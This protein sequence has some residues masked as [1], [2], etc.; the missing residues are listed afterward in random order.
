MKSGKKICAY[1][2]WII[3]GISFVIMMIYE[4]FKG[5]GIVGALCYYFINMSFFTYPKDYKK[6]DGNIKIRLLKPNKV[7]KK[8]KINDFN[9]NKDENCME[10]KMETKYCTYCGKE[11]KDNWNFCNHCGN[12]LK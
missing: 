2:S 1:N 6:E 12:S 11:I 5:L 10:I 8:N 9:E 4:G 7:D 3:F